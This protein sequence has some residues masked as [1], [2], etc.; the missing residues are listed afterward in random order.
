MTEFTGLDLEMAIE[1]HYH[2]VVDLLE[3]LLLFIFR[4]IKERY[5]A[6]IEAV[7]KQYPSEDFLLPESGALRLTFKEGVKMLQAA[8][9]TDEDGKPIGDM[10]DLR[11]V[12]HVA[13]PL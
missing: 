7:R 12:Y 13:N 8:G 6:E 10:D 5:S 1:E 4:G 9:A 3:G 11:F 2:E